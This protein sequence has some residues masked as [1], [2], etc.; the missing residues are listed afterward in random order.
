VFPAFALVGATLS[1]LV[2]A[3]RRRPPDRAIVRLL[4]GAAI[5]TALLV[6]LAGVVRSGHAWSD[7]ARNL[8]KHTS[9]PSPNRMGLGALIAF[10]AKA[11]P[12]PS[13]PTSVEAY[14]RWEDA[15][16]RVLRARRPLWMALA[17]V[18]VV[19]VAF[20][21]RDQPA[22]VACLLGLLLIPLGRPLACYYYAFV[23][24]LPLA[25]ERRGDTAGIV[26]ALALASGVV[27]RLTTFG[28][29]QQ[30]AAQS[31][32]V[33]LAFAFLLS[34]FVS[35]PSGPEQAAEGN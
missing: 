35:R 5:T 14:E 19:F 21:L 33:M 34:S 29:Y 2:S 24:A 25:S 31:L 17:L 23:A 18:G 3:L 11:T 1:L 4:L 9:V 15:Q 28:V 16:V 22:W 20:A 26:V 12:Q 7:F 8:A 10:E 13:A 6:P 32:L 27:A 30:Y